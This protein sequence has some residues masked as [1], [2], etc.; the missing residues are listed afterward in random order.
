MDP[1]ILKL[2]SS[3]VP[4]AFEAIKGLKERG[5]QVIPSLVN[6]LQGDNPS[7]KTMA[8]VVL[9]ELGESARDAV[10]WLVPLL[11]DENE[12][13]RMASA[14]TLSRIGRDSLPHLLEVFEAEN[15][16]A[17]FW[18]AWAISLIDAS[19]INDRAVELLE[20]IRNNPQSPIEMIAAEESLGKVIAKRIQPFGRD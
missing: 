2:G 5:I 6:V 16:R 11:S 13:T 12:Q 7:I 3:S 18:A 15:V 1:Q 19:Y 14:L 20:N 10:P 4:E 17:S 8:V 9:G